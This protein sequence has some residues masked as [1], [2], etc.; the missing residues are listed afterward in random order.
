MIQ[1]DA[2]CVGSQKQDVGALVAK[3]KVP[4]LQF[5]AGSDHADA[6][7]GASEEKTLKAT[8]GEFTTAFREF[9]EMPHG[10]FCARCFAMS[11]L[12]SSL[13]CTGWVVRPKDAAVS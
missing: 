13:D 6:K 3:V 1:L 9:K 4:V 12:N 10:A 2:G 11:V 7:P 5:S 8:N